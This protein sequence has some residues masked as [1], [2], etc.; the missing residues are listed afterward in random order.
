MLPDFPWDSL[1]AAG[2]RARAH[3]DGIVDLSMGTPVDPTPEIVARALAEHANAPGYPTAAGTDELREAAAG[4]LRRRLGVAA[5]P[6]AILPTIG[7]KETVAWLPTLLGVQPG[8]TVLIPELA[9]P[10]YEVGAVLARASAVRVSA[11]PTSAAGVAMVW[12]NSPANPH[13]AVLT[14]AELRAWST[15][16]REH[17]V[18]IVVDE[19]YLELGWDIEPVSVLHPDV[20]GDDHHGL[21]A[22]HSLSKRSN[23]AGYR[24]GLLVGDPDLVRTVWNLRRHSGLLVPTPIQAAMAAAYADDWHVVEQRERYRRRRESLAVALTGAGF[25]IEHSEAGLYLWAT[26]GE[27]AEQSVDRL[28][29]LGILV[30]P[31]TFYGPA[32]ARHV[33]LAL[34]ATDERI[35]AA[36]ARL[37]ESAGPLG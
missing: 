19:C 26:R 15:W 8:A 2:D 36:A 4:W 25:T 7:S 3:P 27:S 23:L 16:G 9:Y 28:A 17:A 6:E 11:P 20:A 33:R 31:G 18:P 22:V 21:L 5:A 13:G 35:A 1:R 24:G 30:A 12:L 37:A 32:G 29:E 34:T 10:T 14:V